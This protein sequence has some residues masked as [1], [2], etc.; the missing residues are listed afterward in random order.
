MLRSVFWGFAAFIV[1]LL[2]ASMI[3]A[4][5]S[6]KV[7]L[8]TAIGHRIAT[9]Y[10]DLADWIEPAPPPENKTHALLTWK[11][12]DG[13][14]DDNLMWSRMWK[15]HKEYIAKFDD[16]ES[17]MNEKIDGINS[18]IDKIKEDLPDLMVIRRHPDERLEITDDFW[19]ALL[20]KAQS[21]SDDATWIQFLEANSQKVQRLE[22]TPIDTSTARPQ[23]IHRDDFAKAMRKQYETLSGDVEQKIAEA[24]KQHEIQTKSLIHDEVRRALMVNIRI[25]S[26]AQSNLLA[27]YELNL[28][29]PNYFSTGLG[30]L[31]EPDLTSSTHDG[32]SSSLAGRYL[33]SFTGHYL[34]IGR[35][36]NP[37]IAALA[38]WDEFGECWCAAP[39]PIRGYAQL[40]VALHRRMFPKQVTVEHAPISMSPSGNTG[41]APRNVELW[42]KTDQPIKHEFGQS[43]HTCMD[44]NG[45][46]G[47]GYVCLGAFKYNIYGAN[48]VQT[49]DLD[50]ELAVPTNR[51]VVQV[52]S[53][54]GAPNTCIYR[55]R[56]HGAD[57][58]EAPEY[59]VTLYD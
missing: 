35:R 27:N 17:A 49:F 43:H 3:S 21:K 39:S 58:E 46:K 23:I 28:K 10:Y 34:G 22:S 30:A 48:H 19:N 57:A 13:S 32:R 14:L 2:L 7:G 59:D 8:H 12:G 4:A 41:N 50:A 52:T 42:A 15:N 26:L 51:V 54:W 5:G 47:Q 55:V 18:A 31:I 1:A 40:G 45:L 37:P 53:N 24:M 38:R 11:F 36:P 20:S 9:A 33:S 6:R 44:P 25:Q 56:L 29:K 16:V